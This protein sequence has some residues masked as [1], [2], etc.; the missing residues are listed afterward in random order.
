MKYRS[1][2]ITIFFRFAHLDVEEAIKRPSVYADDAPQFKRDSDFSR[3][4]SIRDVDV[5]AA[6]KRQSITVHNHDFEIVEAMKRRSALH[7]NKYVVN[8]K[9]L[10]VVRTDIPETVD[11]KADEKAAEGTC[12]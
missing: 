1:A 6:K 3:T 5:L 12:F 10:S 7:R 11:E 9:R 4:S 2:Y 8:E